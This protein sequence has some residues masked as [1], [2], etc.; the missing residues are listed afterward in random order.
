M[1][2]KQI[3]NADKKMIE[4][5]IPAIRFRA[6]YKGHSGTHSRRDSEEE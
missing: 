3:E 4:E 1:L 6:S 5:I 2:K